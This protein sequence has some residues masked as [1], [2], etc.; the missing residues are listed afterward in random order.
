VNITSAT[1]DSYTINSV[2]PGDEGD[3]HC[4]V[5]GTC[6]NINSDVATLTIGTATLITSQPSGSTVCEGNDYTF[7]LTATGS[8]LSY[9]WQKD[10]VNIGTDS[11][12]FTLTNVSMADAG[13]YTCVVTG[14]CGNITSDMC[15]FGVNTVP[16][17]SI[18]STGPLCTQDAAVTLSASP[19][20]GTWSGNGV[21]GN[22]FDPATAGVGLHLIHYQATNGSCS[23][24]DST[25]ILVGSQPVVNTSIVDASSSVAIDGSVTASASGGL[26]PYSY[27]WSN[28]D[29]DSI[30][31]NVPAGEYSLTVADV[32]GC[33]TILSPIIIDFPDVLS[34]PKHS[35]IDIYPNPT[36]KALFIYT[37]QMNTGNIDI[38]NVLG[39]RIFHKTFHSNELQLNVEDI[40]SGMYFIRIYNENTDIVRMVKIY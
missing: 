15:P 26:A 11:P 24:T 31:E 5:S 7:T 18:D 10:G 21:S 13:I 36:D 40:E 4:I 29:N 33:E 22:N 30:M 25:L 37:G 35:E 12:S 6:G 17:I 1:S 20:G 2:A 32:A 34:Q 27:A 38:L 9:Q 28:G 23:T 14:D 19:S 39:Q 16:E 3:Y 8:N